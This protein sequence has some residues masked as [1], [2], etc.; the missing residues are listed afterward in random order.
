MIFSMLIQIKEQTFYKE[1]SAKLTKTQ[2]HMPFLLVSCTHF[3]S[4][5]LVSTVKYFFSHHN[6][7]KNIHVLYV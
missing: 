1:E 6:F 5:G 2:C 4:V 3:T 7:V